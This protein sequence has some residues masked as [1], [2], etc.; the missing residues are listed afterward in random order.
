MRIG[1]RWSRPDD[2]GNTQ[3]EARRA[4]N[5]TSPDPFMEH[6]RREREEQ[7]DPESD[8]WLDERQRRA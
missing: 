8:D 4:D 5:L 2:P 3:H 1:A 7:N 6:P